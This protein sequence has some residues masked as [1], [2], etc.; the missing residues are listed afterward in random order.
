MK[1]L[2]VLGLVILS[3]A[4]NAQ[5]VIRQGAL[6][7]SITEEHYFDTISKLDHWY[8]VDRYYPDTNKLEQTKI[9]VWGAG[10][11]VSSLPKSEKQ[12]CHFILMRQG[13]DPEGKINKKQRIDG[14][15]SDED[16]WFKFQKRFYNK[17]GRLMYVEKKRL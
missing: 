4:I 1:Y 5:G 7:D 15:I 9:K 16:Q 11:V 2:I 8:Q 14:W 13:F 3:C 10:C 6:L 12:K 17:K